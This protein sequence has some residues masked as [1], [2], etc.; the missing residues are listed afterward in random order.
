MAQGQG[1]K[2]SAVPQVIWGILAILVGSAALGVAI[3]AIQA[4]RQPVDNAVPLLVACIILAVVAAVFTLA[5]VLTAATRKTRL[6]M[7]R[8]RAQH[9]DEPWL[10]AA[11]WRQGR[12]QAVAGG[13]A[14]VALIIF[15]SLWNAIVVGASVVCFQRGDTP[16]RAWVFLA[17]FAL[18][19]FFLIGMAVYV[20]LQTRKFDRAVFQ[21]R[22]L[23]GMLGGSL[24]G[25]LQFPPQL[26][27]GVEVKL[28]LE[29]ESI[30]GTG[31][32][33][34][35]RSL[36][37][38]ATRLRA[39]AGFLPVS[40]QI[41]SNLPP[42]DNPD[43]RGS[44]RIRWWL[45]ATASV[46]GV[47]Y[48]DLFEVP[49]FAP[50]NYRSLAEG[51]V[52]ASRPVSPPAETRSRIIESGVSRMVVALPGVRY[53]GCGLITALLLPLIALPIGFMFDAGPRFVI[54][55]IGLLLGI[56]TLALLCK[57]FLVIPVRIEIDR[58]S[59][60]VFCGKGPLRRTRRVPLRDIL[61]FKYTSSGDPPTQRIDVHTRDGRS[62]LVSEDLSGSEETK[63]LTIELTRAV[64]RYRA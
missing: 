37:Q 4:F 12:I 64:Q 49:V 3:L 31:R 5:T 28:E 15:A 30:S 41:P 42:S 46:P 18:A 59:L 60:R 50:S 8:G 2:I 61:Q 55:G 43:N 16:M 25:I 20:T 47:D 27:S 35:S 44:N 13:G 19:G 22:R 10:W 36:W 23:P 45:K 24:E 54:Y 51:I 58:D 34:T 6:A 11:E 38:D 14:A 26:P 56:A 32:T 57:S 7:A 33:R 52:D 39:S 40:F 17:V 29:C 1:K 53:W 63:W 9:P 48:S 62:W 21:M